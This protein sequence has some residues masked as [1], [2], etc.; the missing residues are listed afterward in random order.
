[1][2]IRLLLLGPY[3]TK[4]RMLFTYQKGVLDYNGLST[5]IM[6]EM[7]HCPTAYGV[8]NFKL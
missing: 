4:K 5:S 2:G 8:S 1:M 3:R 6:Y 7:M